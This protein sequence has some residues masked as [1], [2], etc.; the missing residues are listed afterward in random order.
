VSF[1]GAQCSGLLPVTAKTAVMG[2]G[3]CRSG[4]RW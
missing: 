3:W 1:P 2:S 4:R